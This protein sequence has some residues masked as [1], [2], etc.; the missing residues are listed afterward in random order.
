M[1]DPHTTLPSPSYPYMSS[2]SSPSCAGLSAGGPEGDDSPVAAS[3]DEAAVSAPL[4]LVIV[5]GAGAGVVGTAV[6]AGDGN[7]AGASK[8][9][10]MPPPMS[11]RSRF[12]ASASFLSH[13]KYACR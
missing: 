5:V 9:G 11:L 8:A 1:P 3:V 13:A 6:G 12:A 4:V 2:S 10:C 7:G